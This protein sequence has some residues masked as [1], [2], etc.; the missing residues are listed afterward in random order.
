MYFTKSFALIVVVL[1]LLP[2]QSFS[3]CPS[4]TI[5][6][7]TQQDV[8]DF[9]VNYSNC[10]DVIGNLVIDGANIVDL[11][12][13]NSIETISGRLDIFNT[14]CLDIQFDNLVDLGGRFLIDNNTL[15]DKISGFGSLDNVGGQF[16]IR[17]NDQLD[18]L[19]GFQ[20]F[21]IANDDFWIVTNPELL[22]IAP[23]PSLQN[24]GGS[25]QIRINHKLEDIT[26]FNSL[27]SVTENLEITGFEIKTIDGFS[28]LIS[29]NG[30]FKVSN[31][32]KLNSVN[33]F[34]N[35]Q[36]IGGKFEFRVNSL[37]T[38]LTWLSSLN[39]IGG[40]VVLTSNNSLSMCEI[41]CLLNITNNIGGV[42][43]VSNNAPGCN[44][45]LEI[46]SSCA[47]PCDGVNV[48]VNPVVDNINSAE[49][50]LSSDAIVNSSQS[51]LYEAGDNISLDVGFEVALGTTFTAQI[52]PCFN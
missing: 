15:L 49:I 45:V 7:N 24:I 12:P 52:W 1:V 18:S 48:Y 22:Y 31:N 47:N 26:G 23:F 2:T 43:T 44:T 28:N 41:I 11:T 40:D 34:G 16:V 42:I 4:G 14:S 35:L 27:L 36:F 10:T 30:D 46:N 38:D 37:I 25:F 39:S 20:N 13:L 5:T 21:T 6:L 29:I 3:Q 50:S 19:L 32:L 33:A 51:I 8:I 9:S 17:N